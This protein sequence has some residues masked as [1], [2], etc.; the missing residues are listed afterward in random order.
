MQRNLLAIF[1]SFLFLSVPNCCCKDN[2][3]PAV[4]QAYQQTLTV[5]H[6]NNQD[7]QLYTIE[8]AGCMEQEQ[9]YTRAIRRCVPISE[10]SEIWKGGPHWCKSSYLSLPFSPSHLLTLPRLFFPGGQAA[11]CR[12]QFSSDKSKV[13]VQYVKYGKRCAH[14][15]VTIIKF[16]VL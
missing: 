5:H 12:K 7:S 3:L 8:V 13:V 2:H 1:I 15:E 6:P 14:T 10:T 9:S 16:Q 11:R 4:A